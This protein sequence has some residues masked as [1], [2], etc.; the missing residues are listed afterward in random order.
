[1]VGTRV[2]FVHLRRNVSIARLLLETQEF[3]RY[4]NTLKGVGA[5]G[6]AGRVAP[7][8]EELWP[9]V[10]AGILR[11]VAAVLLHHAARLD[12]HGTE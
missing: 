9:P 8:Y 10:L 1:M 3:F 5:A 4:L 6:H 7:T 11:D 2:K 12:G